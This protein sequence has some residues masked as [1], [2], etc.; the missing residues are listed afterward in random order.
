MRRTFPNPIGLSVIDLFSCAFTAL[1]ILNL[2][3]D[4][5]DSA[6]P[7]NTTG[8][9]FIFAELDDK[10]RTAGYTLGLQ[11]ELAGTDYSS[12]Q[13]SGEISWVSP[14]GR[15]QASNLPSHLSSGTK[16]TVLLR[17]LP[18][19]PT[20]QSTI[21]CSITSTLG[22]SSTLDLSASNLWRVT[23]IMQ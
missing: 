20:P 5:S 21:K 12:W 14:P 18:A 2:L 1:F 9:E 13:Q 4:E 6:D 8:L 11:F 16:V 7:Q 10:H 22:T 19:G 23:A 17:E 3:S 15:I